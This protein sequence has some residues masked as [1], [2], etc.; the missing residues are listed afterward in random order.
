M[1]DFD[2]DELR[3]E[4]ADFAPPEKKI[5]RSAREE[6]I[7]AGFE[8]ILRFVEAHG[9]A[10]RHGEDLDIFERLYAVRLDRI[11]AQA[12]CRDL[13]APLDRHGL[14]GEPRDSVGEEAAEFIS[15]EDLLAELGGGQTKTTSPTC[16]M[17]AR[18]RRS[19]VPMRS[20]TA[21]PVAISRPS[22][23]YSRPYARS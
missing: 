15:D 14:L 7:I 4:L 5:G 16:A 22:N 13:V 2:L 9:R 19:R 1:A 6:R 8:D 10:P 17:C 23:R 11:R 3:A 12:D 21:S 20:P 18:V